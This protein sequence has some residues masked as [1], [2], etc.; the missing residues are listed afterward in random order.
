MIEHRRVQLDWPKDREFRILSIDG[1]GIRGIFPATFLA[2]LEERYLNGPSV[3]RYFD[4]ITGTSTGG[5]IALGLGAGIKASKI[6]NLYLTEGSKIF[7]PTN[8]LVQ[9]VRKIRGIIRYRYSEKVLVDVLTEFL[10]DRALNDSQTRLCIPSCDGRYGDVYVFKTPHHQD[11]RKDGEEKMT[12]VAT[13]TSAAPTFFKPMDDGP[14]TFIDGG[15]WANNPIM[16][17]LSDALSCFSV[18]RENIRI[19]SLGC[20]SAAYTVTK[21]QRICGGLFQWRKIIDAAMHLQSLSA[22]G[23]AGLLIGRHNIIRVDAPMLDKQIELDDWLR[24]SKELPTAAMD[25]LDRCG[26]SVASIFLK[27]PVDEYLPH[28]HN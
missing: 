26:G 10:G 8:S 14:F 15:I 24:A 11:F 7:P 19:L 28:L 27:D 13:A 21:S 3:A 18:P 2:G 23:Q 9:T 16:I 4:L 12:K 20:G 1:G 22:W 6:Q 5:I 25:A 17:G